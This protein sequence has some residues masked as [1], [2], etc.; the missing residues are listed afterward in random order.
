MNVKVLKNNE[1]MVVK[2]KIMNQALEYSVNKWEWPK[3]W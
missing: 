1:G 2:R 3:V